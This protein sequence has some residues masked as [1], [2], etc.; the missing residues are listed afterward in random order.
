MAGAGGADA[1]AA[2]RAMR[3]GGRGNAGRFCRA[4][5]RGIFFERHANTIAGGG[6]YGVIIFFA[7]EIITIL[8]K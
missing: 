7:P 8:D 4:A 1:M 5:P 3:P 2:G 6:K